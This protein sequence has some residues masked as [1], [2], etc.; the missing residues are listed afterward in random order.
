MAW[1]PHAHFRREFLVYCPCHKGVV[2]ADMFGTNR[3]YDIALND[4]SGLGTGL[5]RCDYPS[6]FRGH[7]WPG[8]ASMPL[9]TWSAYEAVCFLDDDVAI[10][11]DR[12]N[13]LFRA[14]QALGLS[15]WQAALERA[16]DSFG[17][18]PHL[19]R[20]S[21][22][23]VRVVQFV[24]V[25]MPVFSKAALATCYPSFTES[26]SGYGLDLLWPKLLGNQGIAVID[27]ISA[28]H[29]RETESASWVMPNGK[30]PGQEC[31]ELVERHGL[32]QWAYRV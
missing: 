28:K 25:M 15:L 27:A 8:I 3:L 19:F 18:H 11:T 4:Y 21:G 31:Q 10:D 20:R 30:T 1:H 2:A 6:N 13:R 9:S 24:E 26:Q 16:A 14:G 29:T 22:C 23:H 12:L 17:T 5:E 7:K 32:E